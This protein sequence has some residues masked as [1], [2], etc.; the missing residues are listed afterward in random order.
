LVDRNVC[1]GALRFED[2]L[3]ALVLNRRIVSGVALFS[4]YLRAKEGVGV[5]HDKRNSFDLIAA[6][7]F[8]V[9]AYSFLCTV[10]AVDEDA[11]IYHRL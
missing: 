9:G 5:R 3:L 8:T 4:S 7:P 10:A 11:P 6:I 2:N 1:N